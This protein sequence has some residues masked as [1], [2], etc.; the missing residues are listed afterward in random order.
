MLVTDLVNARVLLVN[1]AGDSATP[2][3]EG[4]TDRRVIAPVIA[5]GHG[6]NIIVADSAGARLV[7]WS[8]D[9]AGGWT[10][11]GELLGIPDPTGGPHFAR[12]T[13]LG[14][15]GAAS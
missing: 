6:K 2:L 7:R 14:S 13:G 15:T 10:H 11:S 4:S 5:V 1:P 9:G 12:I 3:I 8:P